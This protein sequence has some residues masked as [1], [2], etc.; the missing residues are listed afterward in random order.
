M[1]FAQHLIRTQDSQGIEPMNDASALVQAS[2]QL[3]RSSINVRLLGLWLAVATLQLLSAH[4]F[5]FSWWRTGLY[6]LLGIAM[7][8]TA[9]GA[10]SCQLR[11][12]ATR[13]VFALAPDFD[14]TERSL[15]L[16]RFIGTL[17]LMTEL[18]LVAAFARMAL[19]LFP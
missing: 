12:A 14:F 19:V 16:M 2:W 4:A 6:Y 17:L 9:F 8:L 15:M 18:L 1:N 11:Q 3:Q 13:A 7:A 5:T 10:A